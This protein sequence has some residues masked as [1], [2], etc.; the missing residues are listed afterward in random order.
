M[1]FIRQPLLVLLAVFTITHS[2][3]ALTAPDS[4]SV[5]NVEEGIHVGNGGDVIVC[6]NGDV[7]TRIELLD[8]YEGALLRNMHV[9]LGAAELPIAEKI[10][11]ALK[12]LQ[13][14]DPDRAAYYRGLFSNFWDSSQFLSGIVLSDIPDSQHVALPAGANCRIEQI[15]I[16]RQVT[17]PEDFRYIINKDLWDLL[18]NTSKAGLVLHE[19]LLHEAIAIGIQ[20]SS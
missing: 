17:F 19:I 1:D 5:L 9:S 3:I 12:R 7:V 8:H 10:E 13:R 16:Q 15:A 6:R 2:Q 18:D 11:I 4:I 20:H 14:I